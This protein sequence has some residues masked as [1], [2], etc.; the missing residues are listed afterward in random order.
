MK[1]ILTVVYWIS[2]C[3]SFGCSFIFTYLLRVNKST[4]DKSFLY[5]S[6]ISLL[7][8]VVAF[9]CRFFFK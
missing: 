3:L 8:A 7:I 1:T 6:I 9:A 5:A 2:I 4:A